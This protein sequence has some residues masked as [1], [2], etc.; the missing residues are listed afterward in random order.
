M[1]LSSIVK[2]TSLIEKEQTRKFLYLAC[3][4]FFVCNMGLGL[5]DLRLNGQMRCSRLAVFLIF[6]AKN[7]IRKLFLRFLNEHYSFLI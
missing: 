7:I 2:F 3:L 4:L 5:A 6:S 1:K